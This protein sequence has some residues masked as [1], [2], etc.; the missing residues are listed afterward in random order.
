MYA[1]VRG[2]HHVRRSREDFGRNLDIVVECRGTLHCGAGNVVLNIVECD[3]QEADAFGDL[4][5]YCRSFVGHTDLGWAQCDGVWLRP[6]ISWN[7]A[8][9]R[10]WTFN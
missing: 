3:G 5:L 6:A 10:R 2:R 8:S 7:F 4:P 1:A 9:S